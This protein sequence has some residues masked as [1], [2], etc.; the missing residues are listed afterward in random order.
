MIR[1]SIVTERRTSPKIDGGALDSI[2]RWIGFQG[3]DYSH[4]QQAGCSGGTEDRTDHFN[5]AINRS[6][7]LHWRLIS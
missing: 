6:D 3:K 4:Q 5:C 7:R 1:R 2:V